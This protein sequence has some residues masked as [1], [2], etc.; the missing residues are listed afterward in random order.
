MNNSK[1]NIKGKNVLVTGG[2]G[3]IGSHLCEELV[4]MGASVS[5]V[6]N[7]S[8]GII[9]NL[10]KI[11]N[12]IKFI[13]SSVLSPRFKRLLITNTYDIIF[14]LAGPS[15]VPPSIRNPSYD[16]KNTL[17]ATFNLLET[18]RKNKL[19]SVIIYASSAAVYGNPIRL[20]IRETD[21]TFP[22]SPYGV[23][24]LASERYVNV[25]SQL[26]S[27][28]TASLRFFSVYGPR[29]KKQIVF[30]FIEKLS[31]DPKKLVI[32]GDGTQTRDMVYVNDVIQSLLK[33]A[34]Y[35]QFN[36]NIYNV[37][38]G[39]SY[40]TLKIAQTLINIM[41]I[42]PKLIFTKHIRPGDAAIWKADISKLQK[43]SYVPQYSLEEGLRSTL[44]W[45]NND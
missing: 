33:V 26:Y 45:Y 10:K 44:N 24:K 11:I 19:P 29:Q 35:S 14:H 25:Y 3:F 23:S 2:A 39:K 40:T 6:D 5:V 15:Y 22:I 34:L 17:T 7:L 13:K 4:S 28:K 36:G 8:S 38:C 30:D 21:P 27:I 31:N 1:F 41:K 20:P 18:V 43:L 32:I 16:C 42:N 12:K 9:N 37:A